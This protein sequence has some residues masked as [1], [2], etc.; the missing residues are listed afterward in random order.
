[1]PG[2][3]TI[4]AV[5]GPHGYYVLALRGRCREQVCGSTLVG[6]YAVRKRTGC[7][8]E[9]NVAEWKLGPPIGGRR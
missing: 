8:F 3:E 5:D 9:W 2:C 1:M 7:V 4:G 6:W